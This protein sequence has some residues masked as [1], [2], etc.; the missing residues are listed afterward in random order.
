MNKSD[1]IEKVRK[2]VNGLN[3]K[4]ADLVVNALF[5]SM[6]EALASG[7]GIEIRGFGSFK[8]K[9]REAREGRNPKTGETV[10]VAAK[11]VPAFKAGKEL[12]E[13]MN[14]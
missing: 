10:Q 5:D 11:R 2:Q 4:D 3:S 9:K 8:V 14:K 6:T 7:D 12:K 1:L 13:L